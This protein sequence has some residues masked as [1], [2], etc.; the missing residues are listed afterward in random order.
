MH[1]E[2]ESNRRKIFSENELIYLIYIACIC[3]LDQIVLL[4]LLKLQTF[5][6][7]GLI[8]ISE[9][10]GKQIVFKVFDNKH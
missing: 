10:L 3:A 1:K 4:T 8:W 7:E 6:P 5:Y 2:I 9:K